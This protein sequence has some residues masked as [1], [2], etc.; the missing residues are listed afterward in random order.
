MGSVEA[1]KQQTGLTKPTTIQDLLA[2]LKPQVALALPR[3]LNAERM[4]R[5]ALTCVRTTPKLAECEP[6][7]IIASVMIGAQLGLEP[8][9]LGQGYLI[10][11]KNKQGKYICTFVPG[12]QGI[13]DLVN[14][15]G[16]ASAWTG[17]VYQGDEFEWSLGDRPHIDHRPSGDEGVLTHCYSVARIK[18]SDWPIVEVWPLSKI[19][20]HRDKYNNVGQQHYSYRHEEMYGR[21]TPLLQVLK[22]VPRSVELAAVYSLE[23]ASESGTQKLDIED[24]KTVLEGTVVNEPEQHSPTEPTMCGECG[25]IGGHLPSCKYRD[26][27]TTEPSAEAQDERSSSKGRTGG[28]NRF[29]ALFATANAKEIPEEDVKRY[30]YE[31]NGVD[32]M[33]ELTDK[34]LDDVLKWVASVSD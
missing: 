33:T 5:I 9:I 11:Y 3:H 30:A 8:G 4:I 23:G 32:S 24:V 12:W 10:P 6:Q 31:T 34:Q 27:T 15:C 25:A 29:A 22:Y 7:S 14:R 17:A 19:R 20:K 13:L 26:K 28:K 16:K 1:L 18:G 21:K 2:S